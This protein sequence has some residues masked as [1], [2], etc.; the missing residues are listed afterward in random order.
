MHSMIE[1][2]TR[3]QR[4]V[5]SLP[6]GEAYLAYAMV[7]EG[8]IDLQHTVVPAAARRHGVGAELVR[9][10]LSYA[11]ERGLRVIPSCPFVE[12]WLDEHSDERDLLVS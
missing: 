5:D 9:T 7:D 12:S 3:R 6:E 8:T 10:A 4:F 11:R 1:H 2:D